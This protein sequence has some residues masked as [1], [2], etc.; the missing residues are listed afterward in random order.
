MMSKLPLDAISNNQDVKMYVSINLGMFTSLALS[1][2]HTKVI[3]LSWPNDSKMINNLKSNKS[4]PVLG[5]RN[6]CSLFT[7]DN[8]YRFCCSWSGT[9]VFKRTGRTKYQVW[10]YQ[11]THYTNRNISSLKYSPTFWPNRWPECVRGPNRNSIEKNMQKVK[12]CS[13]MMV[14]ISMTTRFMVH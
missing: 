1:S 2:V 10:N 12:R 6:N 9:K 5:F 13:K 8:F 11:R 7:V 3:F 4:C 14:T